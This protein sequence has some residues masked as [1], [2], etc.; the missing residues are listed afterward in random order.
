MARLPT[1]GQDNGTWG[2]VLNDFLAQEHDSAGALKIRTDGTLTGKEDKAAKGQANGY[3]PLDGSSKVPSANLPATATPTDGSVTTAKI[4]SGGI[5]PTAVTGTAVITS[6]M[7]LSD[8]RLTVKKAGTT[9]G[10]RKNLNLIEGSGI[11]LT[12][13][14]QSGSN[15]VDVT[16]AGPTN[17]ASF[18]PLVF[19]Y[20]GA[21]SVSTGTVRFTAPIAMTVIGVSASVGTAPTAAS[22]IIDVKKNGTTIYTTS[23]NRPTITAA[24]NTASET[25]PDITSVSTGD[26]LTVDI[27]QI[28]SSTPG[29]D[30][31]VVLRVR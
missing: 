30:L 10:T 3:A 22:I 18:M 8:A 6:D 24:S 16:I 26:Y 5:D 9:I 31:S 28:G 21:I 27:V 15:T 11:T 12:G 25:T 2:D 20:P 7:R 23:G 19:T 14:D 1:P 17:V 4:A 13:V 29:S